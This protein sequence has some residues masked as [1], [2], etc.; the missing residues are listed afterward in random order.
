MKVEPDSID[1]GLW[2][3]PGKGAGG[4]A[5][6]RGCKHFG[7]GKVVPVTPGAQQLLQ[8]HQPGLRHQARLRKILR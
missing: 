8:L 1:K 2:G 5:E 7:S 6:P 3:P 4:T